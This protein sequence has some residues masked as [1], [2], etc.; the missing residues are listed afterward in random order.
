MAKRLLTHL[1]IL[2]TILTCFAW[3]GGRVFA[4]DAM[5][6]VI[7][8]DC[9]NDE[10]SDGINETWYTLEQGDFYMHIDDDIDT[11]MYYFEDDPNGSTWAECLSPS[12]IIEVQEA[13][14]SS[15][16][17]WNH[18]YFYTT[19]ASGNIV[20]NR[21][22]NVVEGTENEHNLSIYPVKNDLSA[23]VATTSHEGSYDNLPC[24]DG[25]HLHYSQCIINTPIKS[26]D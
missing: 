19:D 4:H 11:I 2:S 9:V 26:S 22:I 25:Y 10:S 6:D 8:D 12:R 24:E 13:Y 7:Y 14:A 17:K 3:G 20:K 5:L 16:E 18:V 1:I 21:L 15:M 23:K